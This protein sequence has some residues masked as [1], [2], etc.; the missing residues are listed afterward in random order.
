MT[1]TLPTIAVTAGAVSLSQSAVSVSAGTVAAGGRVTLTL[2]AKDAN[3]NN[4]TTGGLT[5][6]F[7]ASGGT[8]TGTIGATTDSANGRYTATFTAVTAGTATT[9][10]ATI[11]GVAVTSTL[12]TIQVVAFSVAVVPLAAGAKHACW[13]PQLGTTVCWGSN[14]SGQLGDGTT[15]G[16]VN[17]VVVNTGVPLLTF[18]AVSAGGDHTCALTADG[19]AYCWG[20]NAYGQLGTGNVTQFLTPAAVT[21]GLKFSQILAGNGFTC[22]IAA[23]G[24][25]YCWGKND[26]GQMGVGNTSADSAP[27]AVFGTLTFSRLG[28]WGNN[29]ACGI[30]VGGAVYC[31]GYNGNGE[32]GDGTTTDRLVPTLVQAGGRPFGSI[33][34]ATS[35]TCALAAGGAA[36]CWGDNSV[37]QLGYGTPPTDSPVPGAVQGGYSFTSL[38]GGYNH[39]CGL[40][41]DGS[42]ACWGY[43]AEGANGEGALG[44]GTLVTRL[45]PAPAKVGVVFLMLAAGDRFTCGLRGDFTPL[46][47]GLP[48][49]P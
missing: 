3:G 1:S 34:G 42:A 15:T 4:L 26:G 5:V 49:G 8:S 31:W 20:S 21:G 38:T 23:S 47:W 32:L 18:V 2:Q 19:T 43:N 25:A 24:T 48:I 13:I 29:H 7:T 46:C 10:S 30:A 14:T 40:L 9:V 22:G 39:T 36:Y 44:D 28:L 11:G 41:A 12:P 6:V 33:T 16:S 37:S 45:I 35:H 27:R 17:P